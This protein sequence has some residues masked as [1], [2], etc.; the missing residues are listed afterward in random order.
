MPSETDRPS[1]HTSTAVSFGPGRADPSLLGIRP[2]R[3]RWRRRF[4]RRPALEQTATASQD[5]LTEATALLG[6]DERR[7]PDAQERSGGQLDSRKGGDHGGTRQQR[8][9]VVL[10]QVPQPLPRDAILLRGGCPLLRV[11]F[12]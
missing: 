1:I 6:G 4:R 5:R 12:L 3:G 8:D 9:R 7:R 2:S 11:T 10:H